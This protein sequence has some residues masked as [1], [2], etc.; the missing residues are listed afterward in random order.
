MY[1]DKFPVEHRS[2]SG[3][4]AERTDEDSFVRI[5]VPLTE[6]TSLIQ[7]SPRHYISPRLL[8]SNIAIYVIIHMLAK[9]QKISGNRIISQCTWITPTAFSITDA[10][11]RIIMMMNTSC[12]TNP[13]SSSWRRKLQRKDVHEYEP[14]I[15]R[16]ES[17]KIDKG[18]DVVVMSEVPSHRKDK[19]EDHGDTARFHR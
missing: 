12:G 7:R 11:C 14:E 6:I 1:T 9:K 16:H 18:D 10:R 4:S 15:S 19:K 8:N 13:S 3:I 17:A 2:V 5:L